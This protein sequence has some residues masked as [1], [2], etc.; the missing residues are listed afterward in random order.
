MNV[1]FKK[2]HAT[3]WIYVVHSKH[4]YDKGVYK[5]DC[6]ELVCASK[7][8]VFKLDFRDLPAYVKC[9]LRSLRTDIWFQGGCSI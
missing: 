2:M 5:H 9:R 7:N 8:L 1:E 4:I 3:I 6:L